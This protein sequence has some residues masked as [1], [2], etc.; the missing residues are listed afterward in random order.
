MTDSLKE[1]FQQARLNPQVDKSPKFGW[2]TFWIVMG[3][4]Q[5]GLA[6]LFGVIAGKTTEVVPNR[7]TALVVAVLGIGSAFGLLK[8]KLFG[9]YLVYACLALALLA[10]IM[11]QNQHSC[12]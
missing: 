3:F 6:L 11:A 9:L 5:G 12:V 1:R 2:G 4:F 7:G 10:A 8:R